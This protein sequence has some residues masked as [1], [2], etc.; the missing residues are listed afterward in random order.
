MACL[1]E[2]RVMTELAGAGSVITR[3]SPPISSSP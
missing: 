2:E 3:S 1:G